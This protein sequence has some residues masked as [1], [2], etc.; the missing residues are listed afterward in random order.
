MTSRSSKS[1]STSSSASIIARDRVREELKKISETRVH[2]EDLQ[3]LRKEI[4][5]PETSLPKQKEIVT[6][7]AEKHEAHLGPRFTSID[8][9][10]DTIKDLES[11]VSRLLHESTQAQAELN[12]RRGKL[13]DGLIELLRLHK[14]IEQIDKEISEKTSQFQSKLVEMEQQRLKILENPNLTEEQKKKM[15]NEIDQE[16]N[17]MK[18]THAGTLD[19]LREEKE[20]LKD[21]ARM[22]AQLLQLAVQDLEQQHLSTI[23]EL[24][25]LKI[26]ASPSQIREIEAQIS[27]KQ[28][29]F[30]NSLKVLEQ[31][32]N[33]KQYFFDEHGRHFLNENGEKVYKRDSYSPEYVMGTD[34]NFM[35]VS[36]GTEILTD[37]NGEYY[38]DKYGQKIFTKQFFRAEY[39]Q[40]F[41]DLEGNRLYVS[42]TQSSFDFSESSS[43]I[44]HF[45]C[46]GKLKVFPF[47][48]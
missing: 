3:K 10:Q 22:E 35:K 27:E 37:D 16:L 46:E 44:Q 33:S 34:G 38:L 47:K 42:H 29:Q 8:H 19:L 14:L 25:K 43:E 15:L 11:E 12:K 23:K 7:K 48:S 45:T 5:P 2:V 9:L 39:G 32:A 18:K 24:E 20:K 28:K 4:I 17:E 13:R 1:V 30:E 40:Y 41:I 36:D 31:S 26:D 6:E 21:E